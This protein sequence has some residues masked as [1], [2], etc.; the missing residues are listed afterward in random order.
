VRK[1]MALLVA[2]LW[3]AAAAAD[4]VDTFENGTDI[5]NWFGINQ[6]TWFRT[7][8]GRPGWW[9]NAVEGR[10]EP[11]FQ[12]LPDP[13]NAFAGD[14][15]AK[16][17][18]G[19]SVDLRADAGFDSQGSDGRRITLRLYWTN[20]GQYTTGIEAYRT[21]GIMPKIGN[22]WQSYFFSIPA[23]RATIPPGWTVWKGD[24]TAGTD[25]DWQ[26]LVRH[27]DQVQ[28]IY[29]EIGYMFPVWT[30]DIGMD[31][32]HLLTARSANAHAETAVL[33]SAPPAEEQ[34]AGTS[35]AAR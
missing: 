8:G 35:D 16:H 29:G 34:T 12:F 18:T 11:M 30:W 1:G 14:Y 9:L 5:G 3:V 6:N 26:Y 25:E 4:V 15:A 21:G 19:F 28:I 32:A 2:T 27:V 17:V 13:N 10:G 20:G 33:D 7:E 31:N 22:G 24:G 23:A